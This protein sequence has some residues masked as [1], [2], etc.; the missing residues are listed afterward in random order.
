MKLNSLQIEKTK[1]WLMTIGPKQTVNS[2]V[3]KEEFFNKL[4]NLIK[5]Y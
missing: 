1:S 5:T 2:K 3:I 4:I